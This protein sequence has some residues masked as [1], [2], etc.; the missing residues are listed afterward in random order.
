MSP[1]RAD[2]DIRTALVEAAARVLAEEGPGAV[3]VRRVAKEVGT[4][5]MAVYTH[6]GG[7]EELE[8]AVCM[9]GFEGLARRLNRVRPTDDPIADI[10]ALGRAYRRNAL[11]APH[12]FAA[13]FRRPVDEVLIDES[14]QQIAFATFATLVRATERAQ[15]AG[16]FGSGDPF[17]MALHLWIG[18]HGLVVLEL[19]AAM[20]PP[21][22]A[23]RR[24]AA[25][26]RYVAIAFGDDRQ[27]ADVSVPDP[28]RG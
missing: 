5:T 7:K 9:A 23:A 17:E 6:F 24:L 28:R 1:R 22:D 15:R 4:S 19:G 26:F 2:P 8:R 12:T 3:S 20:G 21:V 27:A 18:V 13:M 11:D 16:R 10:A 14:D 25:H